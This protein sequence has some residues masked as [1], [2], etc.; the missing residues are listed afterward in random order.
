MGRV[1]D[2]D[3]DDPLAPARG[4]LVAVLLWLLFATVIAMGFKI[5]LLWELTV[6]SEF[7]I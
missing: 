2:P 4:C 1:P 5:V 6:N 7:P 3:D